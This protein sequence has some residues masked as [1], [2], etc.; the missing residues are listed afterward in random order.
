MTDPGTGTARDHAQQL[1]WQLRAYRALAR[2]L[3]LAAADPDSPLPP[4]AWTVIDVGCQVTGRFHQPD[5]AEREAA[6]AAWAE[7][8]G[9]VPSS[10]GT[11]AEI[12]LTAERQD[13]KDD[14][15]RIVL[16]ARILPDGAGDDDS[17]EGEAEDG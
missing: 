8:L 6:F 1:A 13:E 16:A 12:R 7:V 5:P 3:D 15:V 10:R 2:I 11:H 9:M 4:A 14:L 17:G